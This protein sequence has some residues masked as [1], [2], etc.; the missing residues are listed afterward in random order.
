MFPFSRPAYFLQRI[1]ILC[2]TRLL[3]NMRILSGIVITS[4]YSRGGGRGWVST[5]DY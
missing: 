1:H 3:W 5:Q 2:D 4:V